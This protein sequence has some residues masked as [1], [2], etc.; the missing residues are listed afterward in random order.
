MDLQLTLIQLI[1]FAIGASLV[2]CFLTFVVANICYGRQPLWRFRKL[3]IR[4]VVCGLLIAGALIYV[5]AKHLPRNI[6]IYDGGE[7]VTRYGINIQSYQFRNRVLLTN[8]TAQEELFYIQ[9]G[10]G[11]NGKEATFEV[12]QKGT[13]LEVYGIPK[14]YLAKAAD[15]KAQH[16]MPVV[17]TEAET[18]A[19]FNGTPNWRTV[20]NIFYRTEMQEQEIEDF[21][22]QKT[23]EAKHRDTLVAKLKTTIH[24]EV[25]VDSALKAVP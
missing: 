12:I 10:E 22:R 19:Y 15:V 17:L 6:E 2:V 14:A 24:P 16:L 9:T 13:P 18:T 3:M 25:I 21:I 7:T 8:R 5:G 1:L 20:K 11:Q 4:T 23:E